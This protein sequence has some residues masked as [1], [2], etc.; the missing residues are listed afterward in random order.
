LDLRQIQPFHLRPVFGDVKEVLGVFARLLKEIELL[1]Y[2]TQVLL[3]EIFLPTAAS[4]DTGI[5][6][7]LADGLRSLL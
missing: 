3:G 2:F 7:E 4:L 6:P 5:P 1:L